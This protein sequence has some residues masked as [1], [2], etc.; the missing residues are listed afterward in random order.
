M[1][2]RIFAALLALVM[3]LSLCACGGQVQP[4]PNKGKLPNSES[5]GG[6]ESGAYDDSLDLLRQEMEGIQPYLFAAAWIGDGADPLEIDVREW[7]DGMSP[8]LCA[9]YTFIKSIPDER[10]IGNGGSLYCVVPR[11][12]DATLVVNRIVWN[13]TFTDYEVAEVLYRSEKGDPILLFVEE[14]GENTACTTTQVNITGSGENVEWLVSAYDYFIAFPTDGEGNDYGYDF[15]PYSDDMG[16]TAPTVEQLTSVNWTWDSETPDG[17]YVIAGMRLEKQSGAA[18]GSV[19]FAWQYAG[20]DYQEI[21]EGRWTLEPDGESNALLRLDME[22]TGGVRYRTG[23]MPVNIEDSFPVQMPKGYE[24]ATYLLISP[25]AGGADLP[26]CGPTGITQI[27][28]ADY[29]VG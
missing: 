10:V 21:Y 16:W 4:D 12:P 17:D 1:K 15:T 19:F 22:C 13:E 6:G 14:D 24:D 25:G 28:F 23:E 5:G 20:E 2:Q 18:D 27:F 11:D 9:R 3:T 8:D 26:G 7:A 29:S